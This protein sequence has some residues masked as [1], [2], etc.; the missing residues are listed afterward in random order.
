MTRIPPRGTASPKGAAGNI[1]IVILDGMIRVYIAII[2]LLLLLTVS[3]VCAQAH[4]GY[5]VTNL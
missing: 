1:R 2:R 4:F 3:Q 5:E